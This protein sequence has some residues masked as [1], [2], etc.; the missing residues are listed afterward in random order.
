MLA[1]MAHK[2]FEGIVRSASCPFY[3]VLRFMSYATIG[4]DEQSPQF[5]FELA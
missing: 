3:V 2:S 1:L 5:F 4:R